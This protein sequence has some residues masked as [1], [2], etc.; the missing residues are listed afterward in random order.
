MA[1]P[2]T[3]SCCPA[4]RHQCLC[5]R[6][7]RQS[8]GRPT[9]WGRRAPIGRRR[10]QRAAEGQALA[11]R[12]GSSSDAICVIARLSEQLGF[13]FCR[14]LPVQGSDSAGCLVEFTWLRIPFDH[15]FFCCCL[16]GL[17]GANLSFCHE[18]GTAEQRIFELN[19]SLY[20]VRLPFLE[21]GVECRACLLQR[22]RMHTRRSRWALGRA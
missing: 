2:S 16:S 21:I 19:L 18:K 22:V 7:R 11:R 6:S 9:T 15:D 10:L 3:L 4:P 1:Q 8:G 5:R 17:R 20:R 13:V 14:D 12:A